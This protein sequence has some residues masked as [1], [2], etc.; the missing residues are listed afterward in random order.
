[1]GSE[2]KG[3]VGSI[4]R[5]LLWLVR[6]T[7]G[8]WKDEGHMSTSLWG[9]LNSIVH[10]SESH[11]ILG[12]PAGGHLLWEVPQSLQGIALLS[13]CHALACDLTCGQFLTNDLGGWGGMRNVW[14]IL[15]RL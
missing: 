7:R 13:W 5:F 9:I 8:P 4:L 6:K 1:M 2:V 15:V 14:A 3:K 10:L 11:L 12:G